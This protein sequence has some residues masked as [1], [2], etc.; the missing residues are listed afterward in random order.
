MLNNVLRC[1][2]I[3]SYLIYLFFYLYK[4]TLYADYKSLPS[5]LTCFRFSNSEQTSRVYQEKE[6]VW[7]RELRRMKAAH[8]GR[9]RAGA[10]RALKLEQMLMMRTHQLQQDRQR[11]GREADTLGARLEET[12]WGLCQKAGEIALLKTQLK[13]AQVCIYLLLTITLFFSH[14]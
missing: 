4:C 6:R 1:K 14:L 11:L 8:D 13:E 5:L 2:S 12:E 3:P 10:Q 9:L 7:E